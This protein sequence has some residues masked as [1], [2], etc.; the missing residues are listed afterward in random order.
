MKKAFSFFPVALIVAT[1]GCGGGHFGSGGGSF[2]T[3]F[4]AG[5]AHVSGNYGFTQNN[6]LVE[7]AQK[8]SDL[9]SDSIFIYLTPYF[10]T[11]YPDQ[12]SNQWPSADPTK[13]AAL[14][15]TRPYDTVLN[16]PFHT[17]V[18]T[19]YSFANADGVAGL[20]ASPARLKAEEK[21]FY[22]LTKYLY[23]KFAG[24]GKTFVLK[25]WESDWIGLSQGNVTGNISPG[26]VQDMIAWLSARQRG[27]TR[28]AT[29]PVVQPACASSMRPRSIAC[30]ITRRTG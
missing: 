18:M 7:G 2:S 27:V 13:F 21:E 23:S 5:I 14:A 9:G 19:V 25:N 12:S 8:I 29:R 10:R 11:E 30:S 17:I 26:M 1:V 15:Q 22:Q 4:A 6:Y 28:R 20:S 16:L 24:S 3:R